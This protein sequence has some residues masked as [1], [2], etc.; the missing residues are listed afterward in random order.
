[1]RRSNVN[2]RGRGGSNDKNSRGRN[3]GRSNERDKYEKE[4]TSDLPSSKQ[5]HYF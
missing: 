4:D 5:F 2:S 1:M 3:Q